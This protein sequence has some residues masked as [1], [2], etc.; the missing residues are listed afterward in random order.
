MLDPYL[1]QFKNDISTIEIANE[2]NNPF[3][4][5]IPEIAK[6]AAQEF[7]GYITR[8]SQGGAYDFETQ[9]GKMFGVL[10]VKKNNNRLAYL[11][12]LSGTT[13]GSIPNKKLVPPIFNENE[14]EAILT[15]GLN[16]LAELTQKIKSTKE[17]HAINNLKAKRKQHSN[18]LQKKL[19]IKTEI[20]NRN[21][22]YKNVLDIFTDF[23]ESYP[24]AAAG[25]CAAPKLLQF[26]FQQGLKPMALAEFWW[27]KTTK[28]KDRKHQGYY[29]ACREK[30]YP[31]LSYMLHPHTF[32]NSISH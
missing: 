19:F 18:D 17:P 4:T 30:C 20:I 27:G 10:V 6:I 22:E 13:Q 11:A 5:S 12:A 16:K 23:A 2:L 21:L 24:P 9:K 8:S 28:N 26:A 3:G 32:Q 15:E 14:S 25:E 7:Q 31:I 1:F 29:P